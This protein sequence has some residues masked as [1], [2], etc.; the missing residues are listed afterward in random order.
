MM[1]LKLRVVKMR[2]MGVVGDDG[3]GY[4]ER[5]LMQMML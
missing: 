2:R 5:A 3:E 4:E 1:I